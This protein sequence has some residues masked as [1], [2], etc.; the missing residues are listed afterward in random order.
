MKK[1]LLSLLILPFVVTAQD[2]DSTKSSN[3][4]Y[5]GLYSFSMS[6]TSLTNW[7]AGGENSLNLSALIRQAADF[8]NEDWTWANTFSATYAVNY[9]GSSALKTGDN[10]EYTTRLDR[11]INEKKTW[12]T[13][14][15]LNF[16]TQFVDGFE[17]REATKPISTFMA[18]GYL[19]A[20]LGFTYKQED[21]TLYVSPVTLKQTYV[22]DDSLSAKG[23]FGVDAGSTLRNEVGASLNASYT[24]AITPTL[25][26]TSN[27]NLFSNYVEN[28]QNIDVNWE[29]IF[30]LQA[31]E[32]ITVSWH[33]HLIYDDDILVQNPDPVSGD[34]TS[35][36][37]QFKSVLGLGIS[38]AFGKY[39][40]D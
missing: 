4:T 12:R 15:F 34:F 17:N 19:T 25:D 38:Y 5:A 30:L 23:A 29:T 10:L 8:E 32:N 26:V 37:T 39:K 31:W 28:P 16:R 9:Q 2:A 20:G 14:A 3:W 7:N 11:N 1:L 22:L 24:K 21:F 33:L 40:E 13:S 6:Q 18:P 35:P 27:L 36:G